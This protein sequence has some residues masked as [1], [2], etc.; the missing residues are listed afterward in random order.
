MSYILKALKKSE[1]E[2][3]RGVVPGL[4]TQHAVAGKSRGAL[5]PWAVAAALVVNAAVVMSGVWRPEIPFLET[6]SQAGDGG[7]VV[8]PPSQPRPAK[9]AETVETAQP[10]EAVETA[11][12]PRGPASSDGLP[13]VPP[14]APAPFATPQQIVAREDTAGRERIVPPAPATPARGA[15]PPAAAAPVARRAEGR[16]VA[17]VEPRRP[18]AVAVPHVGPSP[19][20]APRSTRLRTA[21]AAADAPAR[22]AALGLSRIPRPSKK[23]AAFSA[24]AARRP[25]RLSTES[26]DTQ[27]AD[28]A[29]PDL[30]LALAEPEPPVAERPPE[31]DPYADVPMLWQLP[32][33]IRSSLPEVSL[34]VHVY[35]PDPS[36]RFV[37]VGRRKHREGDTLEGGAKLE[38]ILP[39][40]VVL[41]YL[42]RAYKLRN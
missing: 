39:D 7:A 35:A 19:Q 1:A 37:I 31:P 3:A 25:E 30:A 18:V 17:R 11:A 41:D 10:V 38:A 32:N 21:P 28:P 15:E 5:W 6:G 4:E 29:G 36:S 14:R 16:M 2:R 34:T 26:R 33:S 23:P 9:T 13:T 42:G 40:G 24:P 8:T 20:P 22:R 27:P 12:A